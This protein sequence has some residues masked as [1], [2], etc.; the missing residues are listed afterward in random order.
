MPEYN[1]TTLHRPYYDTV[2]KQL[3]VP[4]GASLGPS[5]GIQSV[6]SPLDKG[7][8]P[9]E[10]LEYRRGELQSGWSQLGNAGMQSLAE[11]VGGGIEGIG[12][13]LDLTSISN[14]LKAGEEEFGNAISNFGKAIKDETRENFPIYS[15]SEGFSPGDWSW[16]MKN[17]SSIVSF[18]PLMAVSGGVVGGISYLG[19]SLGLAGKVSKPLANVLGVG[20]QAITSRKMESA[21][22]AVDS[23]N[24]ILDENLKKGLS[25]TESRQNA[26]IAA[27]SIYNKNW[28]MLGQD[29]IQYA[30]LAG[31]FKGVIKGAE[32]TAGLARVTGKS[33]VDAYA[34]N[35]IKG[36]GNMAGEAFE[37]G[38]QFIVQ[39]E[40]EYLAQKALDPNIESDFSDRMGE[41]F[42][43]GEMWTS[44]FFGAFGAGFMQGTMKG[45]NRALKKGP[46]IETMQ[47]ED[48]K[49]WGAESSRYYKTE[50]VAGEVNNINIHKTNKSVGLANMFLKATSLG[51]M[52]RLKEFA[53]RMSNPSKRDL[54]IYNIT[55]E[56]AK[57]ISEN[58]KELFKEAERYESIHA[59]NIKKFNEN[60]FKSFQLASMASRN[61]YL[62][63]NLQERKVESK[64]N[65]ERLYNKIISADQLSPQGQDILK[66][67]VKIKELSN[68]KAAIEKSIE[69]EKDTAAPS[70]IK[71]YQAAIKNIDK[72]VKEL[73]KNIA[74]LEEERTPEQI[75]S[76]SEVNILPEFFEE[77]SAEYRN[78]S[79]IEL[80]IDSLTDSLKKIYKGEMPFKQE[81]LYRSIDDVQT[82]NEIPDKDDLVKYKDPETKKDIL[83]KVEELDEDKA[84]YTIQPLSILDGSKV[85]I[86]IKVAVENLKL[87][88]DDSASHDDVEPSDMDVPER[89][90]DFIGEGFYI[91]SISYVSSEPISL[92]ST[93][94]KKV[95]RHIEFDKII[96]NPNTD[97]SESFVEFI[98]DYEYNDYWESTSIL[99]ELRE[100]LKAGTVKLSDLSKNQ[101]SDIPI[102][103]QLTINGVEYKS[104]MYLYKGSSDVISVPKIIEIQGEKAITDFIEKQRESAINTRSVILEH[105]TKGNKAFATG[106]SRSKGSQNN[107]GER[108]NLDEAFNQN[109]SD[110]KLAVGDGNGLLQI[111]DGIEPDVSIRVPKGNVFVITNKTAS[112]DKA[113]VQ[114]NNSKLSA[115]HADILFD[116]LRTFYT[117]KKGY[118]SNM[119]DTRVEGLTTGQV[120]DFLAYNGEIQTS[121]EHAQ[122]KNRLGPHMVQKQLFVK[123]DPVTGT[124]MLHYGD[125][126]MN[127]MS[128]KDEKIN[129]KAFVEWATKNKNYPVR[130]SSTRLGLNGINSTFEVPFKIG[131]LEHDGKSSYASL[132]IK[133][134]LVKT[135]VR[136]FVPGSL[137]HRPVVKFNSSTIGTK[138]TVSKLVE[139]KETTPK[140]E[141]IIEQAQN[142]NNLYSF[143]SAS[144]MSNIPVGAEIYI[145]RYE[146]GPNKERIPNNLL[147]GTIESTKGG[148]SIFRVKWGLRTKPDYKPI[149]DLSTDDP[150]IVSHIL[151]ELFVKDV[152]DIKASLAATEH[153][154]NDIKPSEEITDIDIEAKKADIERRRQ[155]EL[156][157]KNAEG[158]SL[159]MLIKDRKKALEKQEKSRDEAI[160]KGIRDLAPWNQGVNMVVSALNRYEKSIKE[161]NAKYDVELAALEQ[162]QTQE[163][164]EEIIVPKKTK[165]IIFDDESDIFREYSSD[166]K[167]EIQDLD[168]ELGRIR[169][170]L[171]KRVSGDFETVDRMINIFRNGRKAFANYRHDSILLYELSEKGTAYHEAYHRVSLAYMTHEER[172]QVYDAAIREYNLRGL[173][174]REVEEYLAEKFREY[175]LARRANMTVVEKVADVIKTFFQRLFN[176]IKFIRS[177][178]RLTSYEVDKVFSAIYR[179]KYKTSKLLPENKNNLKYEFNRM[180][181]YGTDFNSIDNMEV[182]R[183]VIKG[184]TYE[185]IKLNKYSNFD[186]LT[187]LSFEP[188]IKKLENHIRVLKEKLSEKD[189][190]KEEERDLRT[191]I[192]L[193]T[194]VLGYNEVTKYYESFDVVKELIYAELRSMD[195]NPMSNKNPDEFNDESVSLNGEYDKQSFE[196]S[197]KENAQGNI[198][199][200]V[201]FLPKL[202]ATESE[203]AINLSKVRNPITN[204][205]EF[206]DYNEAWDTLLGDLH[207]F[208]DI[209]S[210][211]NRLKELAEIRP[212]YYKLIQSL[213]NNKDNLLKKQFLSTMRK[214]RNSF[215]NAWFQVGTDEFLFNFSDADVRSVS[216]NKLYEWNLN[217]Y[218]SNN[219]IKQKGELA[220]IDKLF[221]SKL[222]EEFTLLDKEVSIKQSTPNFSSQITAYYP[223]ITSLLAKVGIIIDDRTIDKILDSKRGTI[224]TAFSKFIA[225]DV[226]GVIKAIDQFTPTLNNTVSKKF[227][228]DN[229]FKFFGDM[230]A[231]SHPEELSNMVLGPGN[232]QYYSYSNHTN[233]TSLIRDLKL[234]PDIATNML[235]HRFASN[236]R[237]LTQIATEDQVRERL[238][239]KT[240]AGIFSNRGG[241][242]GRDYFD[243]SYIEDY[244]IKLHAIYR[245]L[246]PFPTLSDKKTYYFL[247]GLETI[248]VK[249]VAIEGGKYKL[250]EETLNEIFKQVEVEKQRI[251]EARDERDILLDLKHNKRYKEAKAMEANMVENYHHVKGDYSK[252]N[253]YNF[254]AFK[255]LDYD[256]FNEKDVKL[257]LNTA[258]S[259][260]VSA[261][262]DYAW[263]LDIIFKDESGEWDSN[264]IDT[265]LLN[266]LVKEFGSK[267]AAIVALFSTNVVKS[268]DN[269]LELHK[270]F[271]GDPAF[272]K[273]DTKIDSV[274]TDLGKRLG[275]LIASGEEMALNVNDYGETLT[276]NDF[277]VATLKTQPLQSAYYNDLLEIY[278]AIVGEEKAKKILTPYTKLEQADGQAFITADMYRSISIRIGEWDNDKEEAYKLLISDKEFTAEE[279]VKLHNIVMTPLKTV[280]YGLDSVNGILIPTYDKMSMAPLFRRSLKQLRHTTEDGTIIKSH[281]E[282]LLDRMEGVGEY[283][284]QTKIDMVKMDSATKV[285]NRGSVPLFK[286]KYQSELTDLNKLNTHSQQFKN[287]RRQ[288]VVPT[289]EVEK[290]NV[291]TQFI[292]IAASNLNME[293][294]VYSLNKKKWTGREISN[295][296]NKSLTQLAK[297]GSEKVDIKFGIKNGKVNKKDVVNTMRN[298]AKRDNRPM[299]FI[300]TLF[301][302]NGDF[303]QHPDA[304]PNRKLF[305]SR[306][307]SLISKDTIDRKLLGGQFV[308]VSNL[309]FRKIKSELT[310]ESES[311]RV[312][313]LREDTTDIPFVHKVDGKLQSMGCVVSM[314]LFKSSIPDYDSKTFDE[315]VKYI[316]DNKLDIMGY[317]IPTQG[318]NSTVVLRVVGLLPEQSNDTI[319]LPSEFV[320]LTGSDFDIDKLYLVRKK[321]TF[322]QDGSLKPVEFIVNN[323]DRAYNTMLWHKFYLYKSKLSEEFLNE[324]FDKKYDIIETS[325]R[326]KYLYSEN[327]EKIQS[328]RSQIDGL[329][330]ARYLTRDRDVKQRYTDNIIDL[331]NQ[332]DLLKNDEEILDFRE[333]KSDQRE[334]LTTLVRDELIKQGVLPSFEDFKE[335]SVYEKNIPAAIENNLFDAY[336]SILTSEEHLLYTTSPLGGLTDELRDLADDVN[337]LYEEQE[338]LM[339]SMFTQRTQSKLRLRYA[340]GKKGIGPF[341]LHNS[342]HVLTQMVRYA[343][344]GGV[345]PLQLKREIESKV[346]E[347]LLKAL[348]LSIIT[349]SDDIR[350][351][352]WLSA[353]IDAHVD[354]AKDS[355]IID[356]NINQ[357]TYDAAA[358]LIRTG[359][360]RQ[361]FKYISMEGIKMAS[362]KYM[363]TR[364]SIFRSTPMSINNVVQSTIDSILTNI[365]VED[366]SEIQENIISRRF[367][368]LNGKKDSVEDTHIKKGKTEKNF[369]YWLDQIAALQL[370]LEIKDEA[371]ILTQDVQSTQIDSKKFGSSLSEIQ[372]FF[373]K[374][375]A[376]V[377]NSVEGKT[378]NYEKLIP[379]DSENLYTTEQEGESFIAGY[380]RNGLSKMIETFS[381]ITMNSTVSFIES[382]REILRVLNIKNPSESQ[383]SNISDELYSAII[384]KYVFAS[385]EG[386]DLNSSQIKGLFFGND[387]VFSQ[388]NRLK[389]EYPVLFENNSFLKR[390]D[391]SYDIESSLE[392]YFT[393]KNS[394]FKDSLE[395]DA[396]VYDW[397]DLLK[398]E[399][400]A[401]NRL[402][403]HL[404]L[405]SFYTTG[406]NNKLF[407]F[408]ALIPP[409]MMK[410]V[411]V[412]NRVISMDSIVKGLMNKLVDP[413]FKY[414]LIDVIEDVI[415]HQHVEPS[416]NWSVAMTKIEIGDKAVYSPDKPGRLLLGIS[417]D[418]KPLYVP[419]IKKR[420][421][422]YKLVGIVES[423]NVSTPIYTVEDRKG[424]DKK[425]RFFHQYGLPENI[426]ETNKEKDKIGELTVDIKNKLSQRFAGNFVELSREDIYFN[427]VTKQEEQKVLSEI[428]Y[429]VV[430]VKNKLSNE[431]DPIKI[432]TDGSDIKGTGQIG[433]GVW[434]EYNGVSYGSSTTKTREDIIS[435]FSMTQEEIDA[436]R[437]GDKGKNDNTFS[438]GVMESY[439]IYDALRA[440]ENTGEHL[441]ILSDNEN[442]V[443]QIKKLIDNVVQDKAYHSGE[444]RYSY[445]SGNSTYNVFLKKINPEII[446]MIKQIQSNGG[447]V[448]VSWVKG[449]SSRETNMADITAK[450]TSVKNNIGSL[451]DLVKVKEEPITI[452]SEIYSKLGDKTQSENIILPKDLSLIYISKPNN[453]WSEIEPAFRKVYPNGLVAFRGKTTEFSI[454]NPFDWRVFGVGKATK[455]FIDWIISGNNYNVNEATESKRQDYLN[456]IKKSKGEKILYYSETGS[457]THATVLDYLINKYDWGDSTDGTLYNFTMHSGGAIGADTQWASI[458]KE[459]GLVN[460][461]HYWHGKQT[462]EGNVQI[463]N[464]QLEEGWRHVLIANVTLK[465]KPEA[466]KSLLSRNWFQVKNSDS[467]FAIGKINLDNKTVDGGTG[468]AIQMAVDNKKPTYVFDLNTNTWAQASWNGDGTFFGFEDV[469]STPIL[470][471]NFAG[472]GTRGN[473]GQLPAEAITAIKQVYEETQGEVVKKYCKGK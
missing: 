53:T 41:Y 299:S 46:S 430:M 131:S 121:V 35:A 166:Y 7:A 170:M 101:I 255:G 23:Y 60:K 437:P 70:K 416:S 115:E 11:I 117:R 451:L 315:K 377:K 368:I 54:E 400:P 39:K 139:K 409:S 340:S 140:K 22:E 135:D 293:D 354:L 309:G 221:A 168:K 364:E 420:D 342:H 452:E 187:N 248:P 91:D 259:N 222:L 287:L 93:R 330:E 389:A 174:E 296:I 471:K 109:A 209:D 237:F 431:A 279:E 123:Q 230:Y 267:H 107:V 398:H 257:K 387:S 203:G 408:N 260:L 300:E 274:E 85:G 469:E 384:A 399:D 69:E 319:I 376:S 92:G 178:Y 278:S 40:G 126:V 28:A 134:G 95:V 341:A 68:Y 269:S 59:K 356:L 428:S 133:N 78:L 283:V 252:G 435:E 346:G 270:M 51:N 152:S 458:G 106:I 207:H 439:G 241:D 443:L 447:S 367:N 160:A 272:Y 406:F 156:N 265:S 34:N 199:V 27:A 460:I 307:L 329:K 407:G 310:L 436:V 243:M 326:L 370:F 167:Y 49:T 175:I 80:T 157:K 374:I 333:L 312:K 273:L 188:L 396:V 15:N 194:D 383:L 30:F 263:E 127:F 291:G 347:T 148:K 463:S 219:V 162:T 232:A 369:D 72:Q 297:I 394:S 247:D 142:N 102:K 141:K 454:G 405:Y 236:S 36:F 353:L 391:T 268:I 143:K 26:S 234:N 6:S 184:L 24:T 114:V 45:I 371:A 86:P 304:M 90:E 8:H 56:D 42:K 206:V 31:G 105:L 225:H 327:W 163:S 189:L 177:P 395:I 425:A 82:A 345:S 242:K 226:G 350:V 111:G 38:Y 32:E 253:A 352:D 66:A 281:I 62:I 438:N 393:A 21:M 97:L 13:L 98:I 245:G 426:I 104:G 244:I 17:A 57:I 129:R 220:I 343:M 94:K 282:R 355:Y 456:K 215:I 161:I 202:V 214:H 261:E 382:I 223:R 55:E 87:V 2:A 323:D 180:S 360:G 308:Q 280:Y 154:V 266:S 473:R 442:S 130:K 119:D 271:I 190:T 417:K 235:N 433:S 16:W 179:G 338:S 465:R 61:E 418:G 103:L 288:Q 136:E 359:V 362:K 197:P 20:T 457:P 125:K 218:T 324:Y 290:S 250:S 240:F 462:P 449:K 380:Y 110:I 37:E 275:E 295:I 325:E 67:G 231:K 363:S 344:I 349:G 392:L 317:R 321:Y 43:D 25:V 313:W 155:G 337:E 196:V 159:P 63:E 372:Y 276:K 445:K 464:E 147:I 444:D 74:K 173:S 303:Y 19:K 334:E 1:G 305:E 246:V 251:K 76:D 378:F 88:V 411:S 183:S 176:S 73:N 216:K 402:A 193:F 205:V 448:K 249:F 150:K 381:D 434:L 366:I 138:K 228:S 379:Y 12:Y 466:Y 440:F 122:N 44:A 182:L 208:N 467:I 298:E 116:A 361:T 81:P 264:K 5:I 185:L 289:H 429:S 29:I 413:M 77:V 217:F 198:K 113:L 262:L 332:I 50:M 145:T 286:D 410:G 200:L 446:R 48:V 306:M 316:V 192:D 227:V 422:L 171:G 100:K 137:F 432:F 404:F 468:W 204:M 256:N 421:T 453:F 128:K 373:N 285:G 186:K 365:G 195:L 149:N 153:Q 254:V 124:S 424:Y 4:R 191:R 151:E 375:I 385:K 238:S 83:A 292:K 99:K 239:V 414:N 108:S 351:M 318:Q 339:M 233:V 33:V 397:E 277:S 9:Y 181:V 472:I 229:K 79:S 470:T 169:N 455:M 89:D 388:F 84:F 320:G 419:Y 210:M 357:F 441:H 18:I 322:A 165:D 212:Y 112:G 52:N 301:E 71:S 132:L 211:I 302:S 146:I 224:A 423:S 14:E 75:K 403:R 65:F 450:S 213:E 415:S 158:Y 386:F 390:L 348:D 58:S 336:H 10:N 427:N 335:L 120:I 412:E 294:P 258:V 314:S 201:A 284:G 64:E 172:Q 461:N 358:Y 331:Y 164:T 144:D 328:I 459:Y 96:S 118:L 401:V 311:D 3:A 47:I